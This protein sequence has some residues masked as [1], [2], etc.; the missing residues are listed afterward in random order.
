MAQLPTFLKVSSAFAM[1]TGTADVLLGTRMIESGSGASFPID[2]AAAVLADSQLRFLG[3]MWAGY[4]AILWWVSCDLRERRVP[5]AILGG[6]MVA[7]GAGRAISGALH[8]F[9]SRLWLG[10]MV[11]ELLIPPAIWFLTNWRGADV[12][13]A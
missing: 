2:S 5:L 10:L 11:G 4:G 8:G 1:L 12:K 13:T 9:S 7:G 3:A 6:V